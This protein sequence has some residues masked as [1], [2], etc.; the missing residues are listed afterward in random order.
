MRL[1]SELKTRKV[2]IKLFFSYICIFI[3]PLSLISAVTYGILFDMLENEQNT[4]NINALNQTREMLDYNFSDI[5]TL[6]YQLS[7]NANVFAFERSN[8]ANEN[9]Q[10]LIIKNIIKDCLLYKVS[11][12]FFYLTAIYFKDKDV[13]ITPQ[14]AYKSE[15][16][17]RD[18]IFYEN[19]SYEEWID[20]IN[21]LEKQ[22]IWKD[23]NINVKTQNEKRVITIS[24]PIPM[25]LKAEKICF[26]A[27]IDTDK[28]IRLFNNSFSNREGAIIIFDNEGNNIMSS[29]KFDID[30]ESL[31][32][33][34]GGTE[35]NFIYSLGSQKFVG[36][37]NSSI[38]A[39]IKYVYIIPQKVFTGK[40]SY[41]RNIF[42][43]LNIIF[44]I[45]GFLAVCYISQRNYRPISNILSLINSSLDKIP[46]NFS[47]KDEYQIITDRLKNTLAQYDVLEKRIDEQ[48]PV[49][50][51]NFLNNLLKQVGNGEAVIEKDLS[52]Y[53]V[54]FPHEYFTVIA[55]TID[56]YERFSPGSAPE[57]KNLVVFTIYN[58]IYEVLNQEYIT[59]IVQSDT[60]NIAVIINF[61]G[62]QAADKPE[63]IERKL[64]YIKDF[65]ENSCGICMSISVGAV[66]E[67]FLK[68][69]ESYSTAMHALNYGKMKGTSGVTFFM[70]IRSNYDRIF[71]PID[72]E[73]QLINFIKNGNKDGAYKTLEEIYMLNFNQN[74]ISATMMECLFYNVGATLLKTLADLNLHNSEIYDDCVKIIQSISHAVPAQKLF[75]ELS[76][77][78]SKICDKLN[79]NRKNTNTTLI[80]NILEYVEH[81]YPNP[82]LSLE[83]VAEKFN[84][85]YTYLSK[86]FKENTM[87]NFV[88][89][90]NRLRVEKS[91]ELLTNS[92]LPI[93]EIASKVGYLSANTYIRIFKKYSSITPGQLRLKGK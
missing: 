27:F 77:L 21:S 4:S 48:L 2:F 24:T 16:F 44:L 58:V 13:I 42:I 85:T 33:H 63:E 14:T 89:Y 46:G 5:N 59:Y 76:G 60:E 88:D 90:L 82:S 87:Y 47:D 86:F 35:G 19:Y 69:S 72:S 7:N 52:Y 8:S 15:E 22:T 93:G 92:E 91:K 17:F 67:S 75:D 23:E 71:Y 39:N 65:L 49:L 70:D 28:V 64:N 62:Q 83:E 57:D 50:R 38:K 74:H 41:V 37:Y 51:S 29:A 12:E 43:I 32:E 3:I 6:A 26:L 79:D 34:I 61:P 45:L 68:L 31:K 25:G 84:I 20:R 40:I 11:K 73:I 66:C 10:A 56:S 9:E 30:L 36:V 1:L 78:S 55:I 81:Q 80:K 18:I 54:R 53:G